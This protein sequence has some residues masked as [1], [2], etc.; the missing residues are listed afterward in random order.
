METI[1]FDG[2]WLKVKKTPKG[3]F[4]SERKGINSIAV[5]LYRKI[6]KN[7][8][9]YLE[10]LVRLQPL[11]I[12]NSQSNDD[13][14]IPKLFECPITGSLEEGIS[15]IGQTRIEVMEEAGYDIPEGG[16]KYVGEYYVGTQT[17]EK[18]FMYIVNVDTV[19]T[20]RVDIGGDGSYFESISKNEWKNI[21]EVLDA[22][23]SGLNIIT[24]KL[25]KLWVEEK[26]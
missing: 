20:E 11:P 12:D 2:K 9:E 25:F 1:V 8:R 7:S 19:G 22:K 15:S 4:F 17:N 13:K 24:N 6:I 26:I 10:V 3:Y 18:V 21:F 23:Y 16:F 5:L 14:E